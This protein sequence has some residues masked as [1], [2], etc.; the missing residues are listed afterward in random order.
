MVEHLNQLGVVNYV[1][2]PIFD[3]N[4]MRI[5]VNNN[6]IVSE[7]FNKY[8]RYF[9]N[10][11]SKKIQK[12]IKNSYNISEFDLIHAYTLF[13]DG[14]VSYTLSE[15][16]GIPYVVAVRNTDVNIFLKYFVHLRSRAVKI[17]EKADAIFFLSDTY[18]LQ[19]F[20][21]YIPEFQREKL[22]A[23]SYVIPNGVDDFWLENLYKERVPYCGNKSVKIIFAG[24][25]DQN[26]NIETTQSALKLLEQKGINSIYTVVGRVIDSKT[27]ERIITDKR[28]LYVPSQPKEKL[29]E[30]YRDA[31]VF[32]MPSHKETFGLVYAEAITQGLPVIYTKGQGFD[33]QFDNG[34]VGY[35]VDDNNPTEIAE[36]IIKI[37][38]NYEE[39]SKYCIELCEKFAWDKICRKYAEIYRKIIR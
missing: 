18:K 3:R 10:L 21:K 37:L 28:T 23:K 25:I 22:L 6:V 36:S 29:I 38:S 19:V 13:T 20:E 5:K 31:D 32:V 26:K 33:R 16:F 8:D 39:I 27:L 4:M 12:A 15:E 2:A 24:G 11:K 7:C 1:F 35:S 34:T 9:F 30:Y 17:L 14:N